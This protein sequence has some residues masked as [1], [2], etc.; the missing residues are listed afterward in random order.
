MD[1]RCPQCR[2]GIGN[3]YRGPAP[4]RF[5]LK[6]SNAGSLVCPRCGAGLAMNFHAGETNPGTC[7]E[8]LAFLVG[9][10]TLALLVVAERSTLECLLG[11]ALA[12]AAFLWLRHYRRLAR[13]PA[14]WPRYLL[15]SRD[16]ETSSDG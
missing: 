5:I 4:Y 9:G 11:V 2:S 12:E 1:Y 3:L 15:C 6:P 14:D 13:V 10:V 16:E 7:T 8:F